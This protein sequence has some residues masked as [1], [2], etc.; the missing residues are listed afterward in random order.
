ELGKR[1]EL[2]V[3]GDL[4]ESGAVGVNQEQIEETR[5]ALILVRRKQDLAV[6]GRKRRREA[7]AAEI[8]DLFGA[9]AVGI[10]DKQLHLH[11]RG[12]IFFQQLAILGGLL[13][14]IWMIGA[15]HHLAAVVGKHGAAIVA[16]G[17]GD[18]LLASAVLVHSP[19]FQI[20]GRQGC[21]NDLFSLEIDGAFGVIASGVGQLLDDLALI[22]RE[23]D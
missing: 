9:R 7:R 8:C 1:R 11:G 2:L 10:G 13:C 4:L 5:I 18:A 12:Q 20:A 15:P 3:V 23:I 14:G 17:I 22:G 21:V 19:Q 6:V 16:F